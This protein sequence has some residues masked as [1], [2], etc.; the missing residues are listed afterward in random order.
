MLLVLIIVV[1]YAR[2]NAIELK[3]PLEERK[4]HVNQTRMNVLFQDAR[5][6]FPSS[7]SVELIS[8][9]YICKKH[10]RLEGFVVGER[11]TDFRM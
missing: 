2:T 11:T 5:L 7:S 10:N 3:F 4:K 6:S 1:C 8:F 9:F